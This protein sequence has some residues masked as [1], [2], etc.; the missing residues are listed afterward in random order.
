MWVHLFPSRTQKLS[1]FAP[2]ILGGRL[3]GKIGNA[4]IKRVRRNPGSFFYVLCRRRCPHR[5][6]LSLRGAKRRG[7]LPKQGSMGT[8]GS[9]CF[10][11]RCPAGA[12]SDE[13][14]LLLA[15]RCHSLRSLFPPLAALPSL[16]IPNTEVKHICADNSS[17]HKIQCYIFRKRKISAVSL[18]FL[19]PQRSSAF[20]GAPY[21]FGRLPG[22]IGNANTKRVRRNPGSFSIPVI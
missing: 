17:K 11:L 21:C 4:N 22:K 18:L 9:T 1:T 16:P 2:T 3:P 5:P 20:V 14:D 8:G 19:S 7:N 15:D 13:A 6:V 12:S 10:L